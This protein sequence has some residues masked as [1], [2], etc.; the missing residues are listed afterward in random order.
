MLHGFPRFRDL[1]LRVELIIA[2]TKRLDA[3]VVLLQEV[4][5]T[6]RTGSV[7]QILG[8]ELGYNYLFYR[9][10]GNR[11][12]I[13][14][15]EGEAILSRFPLKDVVHTELMPPAD[16]FQNRVVLGATAV[17]PWGEVRLFDTHLTHT[18]PQV[19]EK[20]VESLRR[21]VEANSRGFGIVSGDF[22][23]KADSAQIQQLDR[24]W[25]DTYKVAH[26]GDPGLTCCV[27]DLT[28][29]PGEPLQ[30]RID[31]IFL[32]SPGWKL[33]SAV[34]AF[35]SPFK[36]GEGWQWASDH[37]GLVVEVEP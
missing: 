1:S 35:Y 10:S 24:V 9:A 12:L 33:V 37:T 8:K 15:E 26:P 22:N 6:T 34:H 30:M 36:V 2:E 31:Y 20:Q 5:W 29:A 4:P 23:A 18:N 3:D 7:A 32:L 11:H 14:F 21:Y 19:N 17:T 25:I 13:F 28:A 27:D 16:L